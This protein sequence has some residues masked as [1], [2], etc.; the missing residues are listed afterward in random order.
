M[1]PEVSAVE[2][3]VIY[4]QIRMFCGWRMSGACLAFTNAGDGYENLP[5]VTSRRVEHCHDRFSNKYQFGRLSVSAVAV[6]N[7]AGRIEQQQHE[8]IGHRRQRSDRNFAE[9]LLSQR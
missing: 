2:K 7:R 1:R 6:T 8:R 5:C 3:C 4:Q 9:R